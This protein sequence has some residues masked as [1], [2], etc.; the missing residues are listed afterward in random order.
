MRLSAYFYC[1]ILAICITKIEFCDEILHFLCTHIIPLINPD[2]IESH[3]L[4]RTEFLLY[5]NRNYSSRFLFP[6]HIEAVSQF[7]EAEI[8]L[9][10]RLCAHKHYASAYSDSTCNVLHD[11][12]TRFEVFMVPEHSVSSV[13]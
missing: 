6:L 10:K 7:L 12:N 8:T 1:C 5:N 13:F 3:Q 2:L 11:F 9:T 4:S